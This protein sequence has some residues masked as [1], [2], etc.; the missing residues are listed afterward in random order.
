MCWCRQRWTRREQQAA[1][2]D[3]TAV[4]LAVLFEL[5]V[6]ERGETDGVRA[7]RAERRL[8]VTD[9]FAARPDVKPAPG[10][11]AFDVLA[12]RVAIEAVGLRIGAGGDRRERWKA[13]GHTSVLGR[14]ST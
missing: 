4:L 6:G 5:P 10:R 2:S 8:F 14:E 11:F 7:G 3:R 9:F 12:A 1:V 13:T